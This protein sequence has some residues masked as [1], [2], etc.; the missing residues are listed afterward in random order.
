MDARKTRSSIEERRTFHRYQVNDFLYFSEHGDTHPLARM[1]NISGGGLLFVTD[2]CLGDM[3][4]IL[5]IDIYW[6]VNA[7]CL[8]DMRCRIVWGE[9]RQPP[10]SR[11]GGDCLVRGGLQ[12]VDLSPMQRAQLEYLIAILGEDG[13]GSVSM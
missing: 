2:T 12:F 1:E 3:F 9:D 4:E 7:Y 6:G 13:S 11:A 8:K 5:R 10:S